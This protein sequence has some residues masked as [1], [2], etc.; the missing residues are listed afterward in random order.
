MGMQS[1]DACL[2]QVLQ[3]IRCHEPTVCYKPICDCRLETQTAK[4]MATCKCVVALA[5]V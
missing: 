1:S 4:E 3:S 2:N 5:P